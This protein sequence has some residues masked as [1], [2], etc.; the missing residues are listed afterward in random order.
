MIVD[1]L[2]L[3]TFYFAA[4]AF[5][6]TAGKTNLRGSSNVSLEH[7][8]DP[9]GGTVVEVMVPMSSSAHLDSKIEKSKCLTRQ[10]SWVTK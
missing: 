1:I 2:S 9:Q 8:R 4:H 6:D 3:S 7:S 10:D 5:N